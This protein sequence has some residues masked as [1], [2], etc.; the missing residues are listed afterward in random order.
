M[1]GRVAGKGAF[2]ALVRLMA[3]LALLSGSLVKPCSAQETGRQQVQRNN[4]VRFSTGTNF[5][6]EEGGIGS[7]KYFA[8]IHLRIGLTEGLRKAV[9]ALAKARDIEGIKK[10]LTYALKEGDGMEGKVAV[11]NALELRHNEAR[12]IDWVNLGTGTDYSGDSTVMGLHKIVHQVPMYFADIHLLIPLTKDAKAGIE[13]LANDEEINSDEMN[14]ITKA[15]ED[16]LAT[17]ETDK[18]ENIKIVNALKLK[19]EKKE[20]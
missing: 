2:A 12:G 17:A 20:R 7:P 9:D 13:T 4:W 5:N 16:A 3:V 1:R 11:I 18:P 19:K 6:G 14:A 15:L 8:E 10:L